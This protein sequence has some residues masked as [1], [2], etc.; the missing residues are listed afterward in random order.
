MHV[1]P[2]DFKKK[3]GKLFWTLPKRP[4][5]ALIFDLNNELHV[6]YVNHYAFLLAKNWN[7]QIEEINISECFGKLKIPEFKP[8]ESAIKNI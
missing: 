3:D 7:I 4:P 8:K 2:L 6:D 5:K 1:Y